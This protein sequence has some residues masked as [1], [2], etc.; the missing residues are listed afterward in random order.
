[1]IDHWRVDE[2]KSV[3]ARNYKDQFDH[4]YHLRFFEYFCTTWQ[5]QQQQKL[6][7]LN[8]EIFLNTNF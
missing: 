5:Q 3:I 2:R 1:M 6:E 4:V 7:I 8:R